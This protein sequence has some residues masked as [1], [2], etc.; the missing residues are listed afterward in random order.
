MTESKLLSLMP[1][2]LRNSFTCASCK[3]SKPVNS[4]GGTGYAIQENG[5][6]ICYK[7]CAPL[8]TSYMLNTGKITLYDC[9]DR[10]LTNWP[11]T[12]TFK[13]IRRSSSFHNMAGKRYDVWF[14][15]DGKAW[16]GVRYGDN[17]QLVH[18]K[19]TKG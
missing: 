7:C 12:L 17:T 14:M 16:H 3:E 15:A 4:S 2:S 1:D 9:G 6:K 10:G 5:A 19:R 13:V 11:G 18:C 8:D